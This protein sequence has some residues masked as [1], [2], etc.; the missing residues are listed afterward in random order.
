[1]DNQ[2]KRKAI[3]LK[4]KYDIIQK[5]ENGCKQSDIC[6]EMS[7]PKSTVC[8]IWKNKDNI[9]SSY[10]K[11]NSK[12]KRLRKSDHVD[13]DKGLLQWFTQK[14]QENVPLSGPILQEKASEMGSKIEGKNFTC[15]RSWIERFKKRNC[16]TGGKIVGESGSVDMNV[17]SNWFTTI[18]PDLRKKYDS[19]DIFNADETGLFYRLTPD[20]TLKFIG[21]SCVGGKMSKVRIT[22]LVAANMSGTEKRKLF[23][24]GKSA[25]PRC[26][27]NRTLPVKYRSN[28]KAWM[29]SELFTEELLQW[30]TELQRKNR[31]IL[32]LVD[33]CPAHPEVPLKKIKLVFMPP[34]TSSKLQPMDQ[35]VIHSLK[36]R[37][38]KIMLLKMLE[39]IDSKQE[40]S[41]SLL[42]AINF[43]HR[44]WQQVTKETIANCF[45]HA[46]FFEAE[47]EFDSD[48]EM[49]LNEWLKKHTKTQETTDIQK[50]VET[51]IKKR[52]E[53]FD[54]EEY[55]S[56][57]DHV[58]S[59]ECL[60]EEQIIQ[61][62]SEGNIQQVQSKIRFK[63]SN[64]FSE[65]A[66]GVISDDEENEEKQP[67][68][69]VIMN[70]PSVKDMTQKITEIRTFLQSRE[71][72][73]NVWNGFCTL[74]EYISNISFSN[75]LVQSKISDYTN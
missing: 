61:S 73:E 3:T 71:V 57:D 51:E 34:N 8:I 74:E 58:V 5:L 37:Y 7:L 42:D 18:W 54:F 27:K 68:A 30:D 12:C 65:A 66:V 1:M 9:L 46:G 2:K 10:G 24:I 26:F 64:S 16:I 11:V 17:V 4:E 32:L 28:S 40:F 36:S 19:N 15:S 41:V 56:I 43:I 29:T 59:T 22:V 72:P 49:P 35:G 25:N 53:N 48:D 20:K 33:N 69:D 31:K 63:L 23:I 62:L 47:D 70:V 45:K 13:V 44:A 6:R 52:L 75:R 55:V 38:R 39:A 60:T 67:E 14:R 50:S 21:E